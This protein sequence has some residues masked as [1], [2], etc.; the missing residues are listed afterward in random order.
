[1][2]DGMNFGH[3]GREVKLVSYRTDDGDDLEGANE[4][5]T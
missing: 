4:T 5:F 2:E 3:R 1:M